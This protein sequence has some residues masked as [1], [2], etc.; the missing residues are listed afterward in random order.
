[1]IKGNYINELNKAIYKNYFTF[2][3]VGLFLD[4]NCYFQLINFLNPGNVNYTVIL[5]SKYWL[6]A[7]IHVSFDT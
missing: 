3:T 5:Q 2:S 1:M 4:S 7:N 6:P